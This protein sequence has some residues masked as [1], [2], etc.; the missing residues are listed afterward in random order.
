MCLDLK[1]RIT[2]LLPLTCLLILVF[3]LPTPLKQAPPPPTIR[4][5]NYFNVSAPG[6]KLKSTSLKSW[7]SNRLHRRKIWSGQ[8]FR[9]TWYCVFCSL[10]FFSS[11]SQERRWQRCLSLAEF[12]SL[13]RWNQLFLLDET[14]KA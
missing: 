1:R 13:G 11:D 3:L 7:Y 14:R 6:A 5:W 8:D 12:S 9:S 4:S 10:Q 2:F